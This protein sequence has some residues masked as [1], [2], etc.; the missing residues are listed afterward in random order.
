MC[1]CVYV[2]VKLYVKELVEYIPLVPVISNM[3]SSIWS[4]ALCAP[5][6]DGACYPLLCVWKPTSCTGYSIVGVTR[7]AINS[8][9]P[10]FRCAVLRFRAD[11]LS[12]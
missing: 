12:R 8:E 10:L 4:P 1:R 2:F 11:L 6:G 3:F 9:T 7:A 5:D